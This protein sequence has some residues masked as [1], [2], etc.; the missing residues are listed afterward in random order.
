MPSA[1]EFAQPSYKWIGERHFVDNLQGWRISLFPGGIGFSFFNYSDEKA[2]R[3]QLSV[4]RE[5]GVDGV[6]SLGCLL[7]RRMGRRLAE[8]ADAPAAALP[9]RGPARPHDPHDL[10]LQHT[11]GRRHHPLPLSTTVSRPSKT[12]TGAG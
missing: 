5:D 8:V 11:E 9:L 3:V 4:A 6:L 2:L 7:L 12:S 1:E 10:L